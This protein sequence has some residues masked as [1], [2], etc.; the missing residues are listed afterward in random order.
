MQKIKP[1]GQK[2]NT[3]Y[4]GANALELLTDSHVRELG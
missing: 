3:S 4:S 2:V 1:Q